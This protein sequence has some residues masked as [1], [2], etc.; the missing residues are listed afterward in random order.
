MRCE[1][2]RLAAQ[3]FYSAF[4]LR[5]GSCFIRALQQIIHTG[6]IKIRQSYQQL[7]RP[8]LYTGFQIAIF[9]LRYPE[10][11]RNL[12]LRQIMILAQC[13][14][15]FIHHITQTENTLDKIFLLHFR[16]IL[17]KIF[18][19]VISMKFIYKKLYAYLAG[20]I[21]ETL[22]MIAQNLVSGNTGW[23]EMNT[24]G[25]KLKNALL[26]AEEQYI[27]EIEE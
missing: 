6:L 7:I 17:S 9:S 22:Q 24:I 4:F 23:S 16:Y 27:N 25:E 14:D 20:Q 19:E 5:I 12:R 11:I 26:T 8:L 13:S 3:R 2:I 21:D 10:C 15:S 18:L 1:P